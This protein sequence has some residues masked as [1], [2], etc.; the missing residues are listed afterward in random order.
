MKPG[1]PPI[2]RIAD[3]SAIFNVIAPVIFCNFTSFTSWSP[4]TNAQITWSFSFWKI[5]AL[6]FFSI[7][8]FKNSATASIVFVPG[9]FTFSSGNSSSAGA[10]IGFNS[11]F[12]AFAA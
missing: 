9:V 10:T 1:T 3:S 2:A 11:D 8:V 5:T 4:R 7:G 6:I 12:S